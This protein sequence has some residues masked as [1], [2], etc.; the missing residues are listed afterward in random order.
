M[1]RTGSNNC[2]RS[3]RGAGDAV[4]AGLGC[5][6]GAVGE[7][8]GEGVVA[9]V[10]ATAAGL[11]VAVA[12]AGAAGVGKGEGVAVIAGEAVAV[13]DGAGLFSL[14]DGDRDGE[15]AAAGEGVGVAFFFVRDR[16]R[17]FGVAV[18]VGFAKNFLI[19][20]TSVSSSTPRA[21]TGAI[22]ASASQ[23]ASK[24]RSVIF[25]SI[26]LTQRPVPAAQLGSFGC[27]RRDPNISDG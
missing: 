20:S 3:R 18:G 4:A 22:S 25:I 9:G 10:V 11:T 23:I 6:A 19:L 1:G 2:D 24:K 13:G 12:E 21:C 26:V 14:G 7:V 15:A 17:P 16:L 8:G 27:P 5:C